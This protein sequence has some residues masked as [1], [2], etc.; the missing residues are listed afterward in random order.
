MQKTVP[1]I[2]ACL[3]GPE[4]RS[5][6]PKKSEGTAWPQQAGAKRTCRH[7]H[8][9]PHHK[10]RKQ[11]SATDATTADGVPWQVCMTTECRYYPLID[12][13]GAATRRSRSGR[14]RGESDQS[15]TVERTVEKTDSWREAGVPQRHP[16]H[17]QISLR[18]TSIHRTTTGRSAISP[19]RR[20]RQASQRSKQAHQC[21]RGTMGSAGKSCMAA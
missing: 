10:G 16:S 15:S 18:A 9:N 2:V 13:P 12:E 8:A 14:P 5:T 6:R 11:C 19:R 4:Q 3:G 7:S 20:G 1:V 21:T 17:Q